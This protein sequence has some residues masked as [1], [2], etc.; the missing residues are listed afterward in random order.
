MAVRRIFSETSLRD[1]W[2]CDVNSLL[3][4]SIQRQADTRPDQAA[5]R[6]LDDEVSYG[7]L[8]QRTTQI[9]ALLR[10]AGVAVGDRVGIYLHKSLESALAIYGI[11]KSGAAYV[12]IDPAMPCRRIAQ[13]LNDCQIAHL[14]TD[15]GKHA[16]LAQLVGEHRTPLRFVLS[17]KR[18][19]TDSSAAHDSLP[20]FEGTTATW[21]DA[22]SYSTTASATAAIKATDLAYIM[23]TSGSTGPPKGIMHTHASG[24]SYAR[25]AHDEYGLRADDRLS[26]HSP[27]HFDMST[28]DF[29]SSALAGATTV[30][31]PEPHMRLPA[32]LASL[33]AQQQLTV[34]YSVPYALVQLVSRGAIHQH[35]VSSLRWVIVGGEALPPRF[36][37]QLADALPHAMF[38]NS[39]GPAEV[40]Q[41]TFHHVAA[42]RLREQPTFPIGTPWPNTRTM[43]VDEDDN[44]VDNDTPGEL[45]IS[46][47][48][49][50]KG[51]WGPPDRSRGVL[52]HTPA[53]GGEQST[54]YRTGDLVKWKDGLLHFLGR[55]DRQIKIR[56][57][58]VE[59]DEIESL[60]T[61]HVGVEDAAVYLV[62]VE[63]SPRIEGAVVLSDDT[64]LSSRQLTRYLRE[65]LPAYCVPSEIRI[66]PELPRTA[67]DKIDR[68]QLQAL[69]ETA[70]CSDFRDQ[71]KC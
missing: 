57:F 62:D 31:I 22:L 14:V 18:F 25:F 45:L 46:T 17:S 47:P 68:Q 26:N 58:R 2:G 48:T 3:F 65:R 23:Y 56:G 9:A 7:L 54:Y 64:R 1:F 10:D 15:H 63:G 13:I 36:F 34:W 41:C 69:S 66:L 59:L 60:L 24:L 38:S 52:L 55:K 70:S 40:N 27:L 61:S 12:P 29:F 20:P 71:G 43:V 4:H 32:S 11:M 53:P 5:I 33:I 37:P 35:D 39:Y 49:M 67:T 16:Q 50:M 8:N 19:D 28:F 6:Y 44:P 51:Y 42:E 21:D 30:I